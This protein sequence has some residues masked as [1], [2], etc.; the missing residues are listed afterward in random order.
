MKGRPSGRTNFACQN[1]CSRP[2]ALV[3]RIP[4]QQDSLD[5]RQPRHC[6]WVACVQHHDG[7]G[8]GVGDIRNQLILV[9]RKTK[10]GPAPVPG[11][12]HRRLY[13]FGCLDC[14]GV[15]GGLL[16]RRD[17]GQPQLR[18]IAGGV[19]WGLPKT[20]MSNDAKTIRAFWESLDGRCIYKPFTAPF[21]TLSET[22][23]L[24]GE[25]LNDLDKL[26]HAPI[27]AQERVHKRLDVR[28]NIFGETLFAAEVETQIAEAE[29]D[30]RLDLSARWRE[31]SLPD[32]V[33]TRLKLLLKD[34]GLQY[35]CIDMRQQPDGHYKFL[36]VN[37]SGQF[38]FVE[39]DT[40]QPLMRALAE[41]VDADDGS[42][43]ERR[44]SQPSS[45]CS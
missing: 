20:I 30:W 37:P 35:G 22:R 39:I 18:R 43:K 4:H 33:G 21:W 3:P 38:L 45:A 11:E 42:R 36:E 40:G 28:V 27:I 6:K 9:A 8:I 12:H 1:I 41:L 19:W 24:T 34:L 17:P 7:V 29:L 13:G 26:R 16:L 2:A 23:P 44:E 5:L 25:D 32:P 31:H 15:I 14:G 10:V